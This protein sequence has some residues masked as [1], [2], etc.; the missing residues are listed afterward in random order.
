MILGHP[1]FRKPARLSDPWQNGKR[2]VTFSILPRPLLP[3]PPLQQLLFCGTSMRSEGFHPCG[4][5]RAFIDFSEP[6]TL[7]T[8]W[9]RTCDSQRN[10]F[11][12]RYLLDRHRIHNLQIEADEADESGSSW[13][14]NTKH[15]KTI[16]NQEREHDGK[17]VDGAA[18]PPSA[19]FLFNV[20]LRSPNQRKNTT[21]LSM[22][23]LTAKHVEQVTRMSAEPCWTCDFGHSSHHRAWDSILVTSSA[24]RLDQTS[25][26]PAIAAIKAWDE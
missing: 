23:K 6:G 26:P 17:A 12:P 4:E 5:H 25:D 7:D 15:H 8:Y 3:P 16:Q 19:F 18:V 24:L 13:D 10:A 9:S 2:G 11:H 14:I 20:C 21:M 22:R 1:H